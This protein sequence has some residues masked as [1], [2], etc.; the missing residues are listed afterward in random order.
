MKEVI[1][2]ARIRAK[3]G[4]HEQLKQELSSLVRQTQ[5]EEGCKQ[6]D[7]HQAQNDPHLFIL[8]EQ[9]TS[10]AAFDTHMEQP[11]TKA[12]FEEIKPALTESTEGTKLNK[13]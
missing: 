1:L 8:W 10:Q 12:Y 6:F 3:P 9:F 7:L 5:T 11:Y 4:K 2:V 13:I